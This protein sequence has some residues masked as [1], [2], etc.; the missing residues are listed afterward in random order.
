MNPGFTSVPFKTETAHGFTTV[1]GVAKFSPAGVVLEYE[2]K[3]L[4][5]VPN[6]VKEVRLPLTEILDISFKKGV[7]RQSA[8]I[9]IRTRTL[10]VLAELPASDG[11]LSLK[12]IKDDIRRGEAAVA[13]LQK[14]L[15]G[16]QDA[17]PPPHTPVSQL[18][19]DESEEE[20]KPLK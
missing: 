7:F 12:L 10:A 18:F 17:L 1:H 16:Y 9:E 6:G 5:L 19:E 11:K 20:T 14:E 2:S 4:G 13:Q 15:S 3:I 8:K